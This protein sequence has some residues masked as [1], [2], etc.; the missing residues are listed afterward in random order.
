[1]HGNY[2]LTFPFQAGHYPFT[3]RFVNHRLAILNTASWKFCIGKKEYG[4]S[5]T[6]CVVYINLVF[7]LCTVLGY[8]CWKASHQS[9]PSW[10]LLLCW[11]GK[12]CIADWSMHVHIKLMVFTLYALLLVLIFRRGAIYHLFLHHAAR[13]VLLL[14]VLQVYPFAVVCTAQRG[15]QCYQLGNQPTHFKVHCSLSCRIL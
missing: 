2:T 11:R 6:D 8:A 12:I 13:C 9:E 1:M 3:I 7:W 4:L 5:L 15:I 10:P 14:V